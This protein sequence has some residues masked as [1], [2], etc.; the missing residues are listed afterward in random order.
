MPE[1]G[2]QRVPFDVAY[3][4]SVLTTGL[5]LSLPETLRLDEAAKKILSDCI[6]SGS[7]T[8]S[9]CKIR[10][11][12]LS[13]YQLSIGNDRLILAPGGEIRTGG[14]G[15]TIP[16]YDEKLRRKF[17]LKVPRLSV[18]GYSAPDHVTLAGNFQRRMDSEYEAFENERQIL[19]RLAHV[20]I[21]QH[22]YGG[23]KPLIET[24]GCVRFFPIVYLNG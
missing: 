14:S 4:L 10:A 19:R 1:S 3:A 17:A 11:D 23:N 21:A 6:E 18:V 13:T 7:F 9:T 16:I 22:F 8:R 24:G 20:N 15:V 2:D 12:A 5:N